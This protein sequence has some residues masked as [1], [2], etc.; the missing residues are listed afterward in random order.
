MAQALQQQLP[1]CSGRGLH[2]PCLPHACSRRLQP[3]RPT[4]HI[5]I[6]SAAAAG[7]GDAGDLQPN[8]SSSKASHPGQQQPEQSGPFTWLKQRLGSSKLDKQKLAE[9][10][11]GEPAFLHTSCQAGVWQRFPVA[12]AMQLWFPCNKQQQN[13][14]APLATNSCRHIRLQQADLV[15]CAGV[16]AVGQVPLLPMV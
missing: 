11:L 5:R 4:R 3:T 15:C 7:A 2:N 1:S 16:S 8:S 12:P 14:C 13:A 6:A 9:Y 10:G